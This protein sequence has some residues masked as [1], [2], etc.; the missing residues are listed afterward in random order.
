MYEYYEKNLINNYYE[1][2]IKIFIENDFFLEV[3]SL[4]THQYKSNT[5]F[6]YFNE[7]GIYFTHTFFKTV[8]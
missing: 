4:L 8:K 5:F 2:N 7:T 3:I 6:C 1:K